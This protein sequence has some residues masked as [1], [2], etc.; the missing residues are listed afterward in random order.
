MGGFQGVRAELAIVAEDHLYA[1]GLAELDLRTWHK[2]MGTDRK[3][4][5]V[6]ADFPIDIDWDFESGALHIVAGQETQVGL[7]LSSGGRLRLSGKRMAGSRAMAGLTTLNLAQG[8]H[9]LKGAMPDRNRLKRLTTHL[10][11]LLT[12]GA[13]SIRVR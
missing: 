11:A 1:K 3:A 9:I 6:V 10:D 4:P 2:T 7:A 13:G 5:L 12:Q 8:K